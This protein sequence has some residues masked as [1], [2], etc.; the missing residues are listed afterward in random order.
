MEVSIYSICVCLDK[1]ADA[2]PMP[3]LGFVH[4]LISNFYKRNSIDPSKSDSHFSSM[5]D[6]FNEFELLQKL[7]KEVDKLKVNLVFSQ[8]TFKNGLLT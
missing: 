5:S 7:Q 4:V 8:E 1:T 3:A 2:G 6:E